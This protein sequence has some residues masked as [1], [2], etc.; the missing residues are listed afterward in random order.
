VVSTARE[1]STHREQAAAATKA[2]NCFCSYQN[3]FHTAPVRN[4]VGRRAGKRLLHGRTGG[5]YGGDAERAS[6]QPNLFM[7]SVILSVFRQGIHH[8]PGGFRFMRANSAAAMIS[9]RLLLM[10]CRKPR[11]CDSV[12]RLARRSA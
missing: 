12:R 4:Q 6:T 5:C 3:A 2:I 10:S 1:E 7:A 9:E 8:A 11:A